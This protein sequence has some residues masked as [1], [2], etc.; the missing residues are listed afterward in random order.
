MAFEVA[1]EGVVVHRQVSDAIV[2]LCARVDNGGGVVSK[3]SEC[4]TIFLTLQFFCVLSSFCVEELYRVIAAGEQ[5][6][7]AS[8]VKVDARVV[9][10]RCRKFA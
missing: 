1:D 3:A 8:V 7:F 2:H 5:E 4:R 9:V 10:S 6:E